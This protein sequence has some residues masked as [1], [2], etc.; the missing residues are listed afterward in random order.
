MERVGRTRTFFDFFWKDVPEGYHRVIALYKGGMRHLWDP[1][2]ETLQRI[3]PAQGDWYFSPGVFPAMQ[4]VSG[5]PNQLRAFYVDLDYGPEKRALAKNAPANLPEARAT[6]STIVRTL[7]PTLPLEAHVMVHTGHGFHLYWLLDTWIREPEWKERA[8]YIRHVL[9][10]EL[11]VVAPADGGV[12]TDSA[13]LLRIPDTFNHK[14]IP[15][16]PIH[17]FYRSSPPYP[18]ERF[19]V[20]APPKLPAVV[21]K[22]LPDW[23]KAD[24]LLKAI[25]A[26]YGD[27]WWDDRNNWR[28][29][30]FALVDFLGKTQECLDLFTR[31]AQRSPKY[32]ETEQMKLWSSIDKTPK[33][34]GP[35]ITVRWL[36]AQAKVATFKSIDVQVGPKKKLSFDQQIDFCQELPFF[37]D[38]LKFNNF[39]YLVEWQGVPLDDRGLLDVRAHLGRQFKIY[40]TNTEAMDL[41][42]HLASRYFAYNPLINYIHHLPEWD[43]RDRIHELCEHFQLLGIERVFFRKFL[44]GAIARG[45]HPGLKRDEVLIIQGATDLHKSLFLRSLVP[46]PNWFRDDF[47]PKLF[48]GDKDQLLGLYGKWIVELPELDATRT[49]NVE[50]L[51]R[52]FSQQE[53]HVRPVYMRLSMRYL[54]QTVFAGT[55]NPMGFLNDPT[56]ERRYW[57]LSV[58]R[59][60]PIDVEYV[61]QNRDQIWAQAKSLFSPSNHETYCLSDAEKKDHYRQVKAYKM[62]DLWETPIQAWIATEESVTTYDIAIHALNIPVDR[63]DTRTQNR[64]NKI[65]SKLDWMSI[66]RKNTLHWLRRH[67]EDYD[68]PPVNEQGVYHEMY[69]AEDP[70]TP[71]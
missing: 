58:K 69:R 65:M 67:E 11:H 37:R 59:T 9:V 48:Q 6:Y 43:R 8:A 25:V 27:E 68:R 56:G 39:Q 38:N 70:G 63:I 13:R 45:L 2:E 51:K 40:L 20:Y 3:H 36:E 33:P 17:A 57:P 35:R 53:D 7:S 50:A 31:Y 41:C 28:N 12:I 18:I 22:P 5:A 66:R 49:T 46:D 4:R 47:T 16:L 21:T 54:R 60:T 34:D 23:Q 14:T 64:I 61:T 24:D 62:E 42:L 71:F 29:A 30:G 32:S 19:S 1:Q 55:T 15:P 44:V 52:F 26:Q 10:D